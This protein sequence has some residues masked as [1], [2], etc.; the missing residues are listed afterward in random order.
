MIARGAYPPGIAI[1][2]VD[3]VRV[4][5]VSR[6]PIREA[7]HKLHADGLIKPLPVGGY[8]AL[9]LGRKELID[10]YTV[11]GVL[12]G[13]SA[14]Q[15]A[16]NRQ[17]DDIIRLRQNLEAID[18]ALEEDYAADEITPFRRFF[19]TIA[20]ASRNDY[21]QAALN[22][23][24]ELFNYRSLALTHPASYEQ[25]RYRHSGIADAIIAQAAARSERLVRDYFAKALAVRLENIK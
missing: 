13:L 14:R 25:I 10:I 11:R 12:E 18:H 5:G 3:L 20:Q 9:E 4:L 15:A 16:E 22:R 21:L 7:L 8:T 2:E 24:T 1:R 17:G 6:T 19:R 23:V